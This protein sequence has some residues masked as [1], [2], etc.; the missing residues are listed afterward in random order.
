MLI[1]RIDQ[2]AEDNLQ[3]R[4]LSPPEFTGKLHDRVVMEGDLI[5]LECVTVGIPAPTVRWMKNDEELFPYGNVM[6]RVSTS[7]LFNLNY[8]W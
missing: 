1:E 4:E 2:V 7:F 5:R 3:I 6:I 8:F